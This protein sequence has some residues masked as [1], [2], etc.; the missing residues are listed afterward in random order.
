MLFQTRKFLIIHFGLVLAIIAGMFNAFPTR[1]ETD[2]TVFSADREAFSPL[3]S[4]AIGN[5]S[6]LG[7]NP[8]GTD[9]A[10]S[11]PFTAEVDVIAVSGTDVYVGG[12]FVNAGGNPTAD[13]VAKWDT[14]TE[15]WSGLGNDGATT[16]NGALKSCVR[17]IAVSGTDVYVGGIPSVWVD[18][19]P[20]PQAAYL[21]KWNGTNWSGLG[22]NGAG[23][24]SINSMVTAIAISGN[25]IFVGGTFTNVKNGATTLYEADYIAKWDALTGNWS[26]LGNNGMGNGALSSHVETI[27]VM[28]SDV[29]V[30]GFFIDVFNG[31]NEIPEATYIA[32]WDG[33]QWSAVGSSG[34]AHNGG[35][36]LNAVYSLATDGTNLYAAGA[37]EN[38]INYDTI[39]TAADHI[40]KWDTLT[41]NWSALGNNGSGNGSLNVTPISIQIDGSDIYVAGGFTDVNN[42]GT[43]LTAAD[44]VAKWDSLTENWS[45]LGSNGSGNGSLNHVVHALRLLGDKLFV[46]GRFTNVNNNGTVL[47]TADYIA[48]YEI[49]DTIAPTALS[50]TRADANPTLA[51]TVDFTVTF[52]EDVTGVDLSDFSLTTDG[53]SDANVSGVN[54][55]GSAYVVTVNRGN[56]YGTIR[57][58]VVDDDSIIDAAFNPLGGPGL[59]NGNF[60]SGEVYTVPQIL[61]LSLNSVAA[62]DGWVLESSETSNVGGTLN[63]TANTFHLGDDKANKQSVGILDFD[64][65]GLP[66]TAVITSVVLMIEKQGLEGTDPFTTH[67]DLLVDIQKPY[68]GG[69]AG[70]EVGDFEATPGLSAVS[71]VD[72]NPVSNWYS[73]IM[74]GAGYAYID[75]AGTTQFR[76]RFALDD[77]DDR[78]ADFMKFYSGKAAAG[79]RPQLIIEYYIP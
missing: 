71:M 48:A 7:S 39:L 25:D 26:A 33:T 1:A 36:I 23:G 32:K 21:A 70:L 57:L 50:I 41:G 30:G 40:A 60:T 3:I 53:I 34:E 47:N 8:A 61:S 52:S 74:D 27:L 72:A 4:S 37:F 64:T 79:N 5:W 73:A 77:N 44:Y 66:D 2:G 38:V 9:G 20:A 58:D 35:P 65:S 68:F 75:L 54:G 28:N 19:S 12:C 43:V 11:H 46:G 49:G 76:L 69:T 13:Y 55:S 29:Y 17:A 59:G 15:T 78:D 51:A 45:A 16:P 31:L 56:G 10:L 62:N 67:G 14:L 63:G 42:N 22:D 24:S 6:A 18:G